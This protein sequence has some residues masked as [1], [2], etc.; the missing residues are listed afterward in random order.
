MCTT[1]LET[2]NEDRQRKYITKS[3]KYVI[4]IMHQKDTAIMTYDHFLIMHGWEKYTQY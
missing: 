4:I 2:K 1:D 3:E